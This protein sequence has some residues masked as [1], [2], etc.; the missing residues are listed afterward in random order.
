VKDITAKSQWSSKKI[1]HR[2]RS[3]PINDRPQGHTRFQEKMGWFYKKKD[4][5]LNSP[6]KHCICSNMYQ[7]YVSFNEIMLNKMVY[8]SMG[9]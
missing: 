3:N 8:I 9:I 7:R 2:W 4:V 6:L 5:K 1:E